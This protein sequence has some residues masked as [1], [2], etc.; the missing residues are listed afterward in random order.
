MLKR[1]SASCVKQSIALTQQ[2]Q[3]LSLVRAYSSVGKG[4]YGEFYVSVSKHDVLLFFLAPI[5]CLR[6]TLTHTHLSYTLSNQ[7][8]TT[9]T[10][11]TLQ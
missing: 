11:T 2:Q 5:F 8:I 4:P 10:T 7:Q 1:I 6:H 3:K 9:T